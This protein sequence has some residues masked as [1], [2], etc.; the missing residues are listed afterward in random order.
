[1]VQMKDLAATCQEIKQQLSDYL[2][3]ELDPAVCAELEQHLRGCDNC[4]VMVDTLH[5]TILL[6]REY[7]RTP[8]PAGV[9][10]RLVRVLKLDKT[11]A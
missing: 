3:G 1:M 6:Y 10:E 7:S 9:H 2:D 4:R 5:K 11:H 8:P